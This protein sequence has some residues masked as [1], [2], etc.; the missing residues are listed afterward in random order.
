MK[1]YDK[2]I[3]KPTYYHH[4]SKENLRS[5]LDNGLLMSYGQAG[6]TYEDRIEHV[7]S[8]YNGIM[9]IFLTTNKGMFKHDDDVTLKVDIEGLKYASDIPSFEDYLDSVW[10]TWKELKRGWRFDESLIPEELNQIVDENGMVFIKSL[11]NDKDVINE[12]IYL[13]QTVAV[14]ENIPP[15][16]IR[17]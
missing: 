15:D 9:P 5:I 12:M 7:K 6:K 17:L 10:G 2:F 1:T 8:F 13:T 14:L 16:R 4:T 11:L 3:K